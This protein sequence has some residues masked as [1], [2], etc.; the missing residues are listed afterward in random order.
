MFKVKV[1]GIKV[2]DDVEINDELAQK[3]LAK[4]D[5][6]LDELKAEVKKSDRARKTCKTLQ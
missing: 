5:A 4:E 1:N 3:L 6:T 2:K